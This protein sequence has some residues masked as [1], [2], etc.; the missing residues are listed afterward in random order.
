MRFWDKFTQLCTENGYKPCTVVDKLDLSRGNIARWKAGGSVSL[1]T[2]RKI[3]EFFSVP[4]ESL[5]TTD[6]EGGENE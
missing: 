3:A 4:M 2:G 6:P 5:A 1:E